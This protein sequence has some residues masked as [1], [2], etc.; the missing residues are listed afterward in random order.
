MKKSLFFMAGLFLLAACNDAKDKEAK[1]KMVKSDLAIEGLK[2]NIS[3]YE[4][5]PY[6]A[7]STGKMGEMDSCCSS[8]YSYDENGN[9]IQST[10]K[11]NK[12]VIKN[13]SAFMRYDNGMWKG[14]KETKG[15]KPSGSMETQ[16]DDKGNY[17]VARSFDSTG[18]PDK[19]YTGLTQNEDGQ[20]LTWKE[21]N[22]DS[23]F[24]QEAEIKYDKGLQTAFT[25]KDSVGKLKSSSVNKYN[26]KGELAEESFTETKKNDKTGK[27]STTTTVSKYTYEAHDDMGNWTQRTKWNDKG[28]ATAI[29]KRAY[30]Y[31]KEE[32]KK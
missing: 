21:Y 32:V 8:L 14:S 10:S 24:T 19:Y 26:D 13:E 18:K 6:K 20:V 5:T 7:D 12:G 11:D 15:G 1:S 4:E 22:K 3:S 23:V 29:T 16:M 28:K 31:R 25:L 17:T 9:G 30:T 2:G 27:D